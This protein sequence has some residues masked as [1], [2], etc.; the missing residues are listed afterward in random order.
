MKKNLGLPACLLA[1]VFAAGCTDDGE[2]IDATLTVVNE[3]NFVIEEIYLTETDNPDWGRNLLGA[4]PLF[5]DEELVLG[6]DCGFYDALLI[7]EEGVE[8]ELEA[9][10]LC[11]NDA[12]WFI[13]DN[14][15]VAF[16]AA[17]KAREAARTE[18]GSAPPAGAAAQ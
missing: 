17:R 14:T 8:C 1:L 7:D 12:T 11:L 15:C 10:D 4:D 3:S 16:E 18:A 6:V 13:N 5:P 9:I 2:V